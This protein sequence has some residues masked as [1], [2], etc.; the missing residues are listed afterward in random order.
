MLQSLIFAMHKTSITGMDV[1]LNVHYLSRRHAEAPRAMKKCLVFITLILLVVLRLEAQDCSALRNESVALPD[2]LIASSSIKL[3]TRTAKDVEEAE[4]AIKKDLLVKLS[5]KIIIEVE[6]GSTSYVKEEGNALTQLFSS[7]TRINSNTKLGNLRFET[8][9]D[10]KYKTLFGRCRLNKT[11]LAESILKDCITRMI[12]LKAE[13]DA[14]ARSNNTVNV[15]PLERKYEAIASDFKTAVFLNH[16]I[17]TT[18]WNLLVAEYNTALS[19]INNSEELLNLQASI[20][21]A[22]DLVN[23][24]AFEEAIALLKALRAKHKLNEELEFQLQQAYDRY[25]SFIRLEASKLVQRHEY[26][27][28]IE[29][30]DNYCEIALCSPEAKALRQEIRIGHFSEAAERLASAILAKEDESGKSYHQQLITLSDIQPERFKEL[31][32]R[33][34]QYKV[35]RLMEKARIERDKRNYWEAYSLLRASEQLYGVN[36]NDVKSLKEE[37]FK[38]IVHQEIA[39]EKKYRP[40]LNSFEFGPE[41]FSNEIPLREIEFYTPS[42]IYLGFSAGLY[43]KYDHGPI[44]DKKGYAVRSDIIGLRMRYIHFSRTFDTQDNLFPD[45][46]GHLLEAGADGVLLRIFHY[47]VS[48]VYNQDTHLNGPMGMSTSLGLRIPIRSL[49]FG[50]DGRYFNDL[51]NYTAINTVFYL[52]G[53]LDF[54]RD[55]TRA[56]KRRVRA[57]LREF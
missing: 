15:R 7:E 52:H 20:N 48:A 47:N 19:T 33:Y 10:D 8:C 49:A 29:L 22:S 39:E 54:R 24:D 43:F 16:R 23:K 3:K 31:D 56:D 57:R 14:Q 32:A 42:A 45:M 6:S 44:S 17:S 30:V 13:I 50:V 21:Q 28:A 46:K 51:E 40:Y 27:H 38:K 4:S 25:L 36:T 55:Y 1:N 12:G 53:K 9:F 11:G 41:G 18:E 35:D 26:D 34:Q 2:E 5:E 37:L